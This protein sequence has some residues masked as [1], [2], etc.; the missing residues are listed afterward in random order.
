MRWVTLVLVVL[1]GCSGEKKETKPT[2]KPYQT[3]V[4]QEN[5]LRVKE[6]MQLDEV[7]LIFSVKGEASTWCVGAH[8][9]GEN[10]PNVWIFQDTDDMNTPSAKLRK[11]F[12]LFDNNDKVVK[13]WHEGL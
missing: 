6:G 8:E 4:T 9:K 10:A 3:P 5:Y 2:E 1:V 7:K 12:V 13:K 11:V